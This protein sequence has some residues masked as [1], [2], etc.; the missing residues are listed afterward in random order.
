MFLFKDFNLVNLVF[1]VCVM[2]VVIFVEFVGFIIVI[3]CVFVVGLSFNKNFLLYCWLG[4]KKVLNNLLY[5]IKYIKV[6]YW[7][8]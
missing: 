1:G 5:L 2:C 4:E 3:S 8:I 6:K 7:S